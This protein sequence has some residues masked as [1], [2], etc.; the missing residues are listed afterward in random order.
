MT[1]IKKACKHLALIL[2]LFAFLAFSG[3]EGTKS[4]DQVDDTV[5]ELA[6]KKNVDRMHEMKKDLG[7]AAKK[8]ADQFKKTKE[9]A[10]DK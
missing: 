2:V 4:R 3:C 9:G 7:E 8:Q 1:W 6:G 10:E 5:E